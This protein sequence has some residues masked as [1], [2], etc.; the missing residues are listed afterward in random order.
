VIDIHPT[1]LVSHFADIEDS[2]RGTKISIG[3]HCRIDSFVKIKPVGGSGNLIIGE[4]V[5]VNS[6]CVL[7]TGN[8]IVIGNDVL[9]A[10]NCTLA[11]VNHE[12]RDP[13]LPISRQGF[14]PSKGGI[15][16]EDN[17]WIGSNTVVLDGAHICS[18]VV[19]SAGSLVI[20]RLDADSIYGGAPAKRLKSRFA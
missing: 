16:I 6:G 17:V 1:A 7:Y 12:Y 11:P 8:G 5:Y 13:R 14:K 20:G 9:L 10:A 18:G 19:V 3:Q 2:I 4:R 15:V